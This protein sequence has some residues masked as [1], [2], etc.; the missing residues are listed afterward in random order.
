MAPMQSTGDRTRSTVLTAR[1]RQAG[2]ATLEFLVIFPLLFS[3]FLLAL[4]IASVWHRHQLSAAL[5]IEAASRESVQPGWGIS[6]LAEDA[7]HAWSMEIQPGFLHLDHTPT[8]QLS[9]TGT[10]SVPWAPFGLNWR[11]P[12]RATTITP[13]WHGMH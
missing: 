3:L 9:V 6:L 11:V 4:A 7:E 12:V 2:Q 1:K 8:Q 5:S 13:R 10:A